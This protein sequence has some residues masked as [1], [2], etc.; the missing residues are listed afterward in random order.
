MKL[1]RPVEITPSM[2]ASTTAVDSEA[3]WTVSSTYAKGERRIYHGNR[4]PSIYQSVI[5]GNQGNQPDM[6]PDEWVRVGPTNVWAPFDGSASTISNS[7]D[8]YEISISMTEMFDTMAFFEAHGNE[9]QIKVTLDYENDE[10]VF[11]KTIGLQDDSRIIDWYAYFLADFDFLRDGVV[12]D[13]PPY[14]AGA[15]VHIKV[16]GVGFT[17]VGEILLGTMV[18]IGEVEMGATHGIRDY[19]RVKEDDFGNV[20][21]QQGG[22]SKKANMLLFVDKSMHRYASRTLTD[23]RHIPTAFIG[24]DDPDYEPLIIFGFIKDWGAEVQYPTKTLIN[25][26]IQ[27][28]K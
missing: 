14:G 16:T 9:I 1:I 7:Q 17:G 6:S 13:I 20:T 5:G 21:M 3:K 23:L 4:G 19:S 8:G 27:G 28:L 18:E 11:D 2:I 25:I 22:W 12:Q 24:S 26:E 15:T 10:V